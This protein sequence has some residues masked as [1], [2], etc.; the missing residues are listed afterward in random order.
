MMSGVKRITTIVN[1]LKTYS[2]IDSLSYDTFDINE[3]IK[4]SMLLCNN[5]LKNNVY[6]KLDLN[7]TLPKIQINEQSVEQV[8]INLIVNAIDSIKIIGSGNIT[9]ASSLNNDM[10]IITIEDDGVGIDVEYPDDIWKPFF[11]TK[12]YGKGT[13]LGL[14]ICQNIIENHGGKI[15][16]EN[17]LTGGAKFTVYLPITSRNNEGKNPNSR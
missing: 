7:E 10:I 12:E 5:L 4:Q 6:V 8:F 15:T 14:S 3:I 13:G 1:A 11:T 16:A 17:L 2:Q 9:I